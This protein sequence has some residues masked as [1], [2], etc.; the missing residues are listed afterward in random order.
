M[1]VL[2]LNAEEAVGWGSARGYCH[3]IQRG[4]N[5]RGDVA[6]KFGVSHKESCTHMVEQLA[7]I[8]LDTAR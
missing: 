8:G 4:F 6:V 5:C 3:I 7:N 1:F 2:A